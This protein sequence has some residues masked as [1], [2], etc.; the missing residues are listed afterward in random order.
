[1]VVVYGSSLSMFLSISPWIGISIIMSSPMGFSDVFC[2]GHW[3]PRRPRWFSPRTF[4]SNAWREVPRRHG[5]GVWSEMDR[6]DGYGVWKAQSW[7]IDNS[8]W[9]NRFT[10]SWGV[11]GLY[12]MFYA[13]RIVWTPLCPSSIT[14]SFGYVWLTR[15]MR[16]YEN[17]GERLKCSIVQP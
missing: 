16:T 12:M 14:R 17:S 5:A 11:M 10:G 6:Y 4:N 9:R 2:A 8:I 15:R 1:M 7:C 13:F 3:K